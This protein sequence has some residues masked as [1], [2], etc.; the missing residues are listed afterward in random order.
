MKIKLRELGHARAGDKG[1]TSMISFF[2]Y[3]H[4]MYDIVRNLLTPE[5]V[6]NHFQ[7]LVT[8]VKRYEVPSLLALHFVMEGALGGGVTSSLALDPHG[9]CRSFL[10]LDMEI[11]IP[12]SAYHRKE[13]K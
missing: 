12:D 1:N 13:A 5:K 2:V 10:L 3:N 7:S 4:T 6:K 8:S 9:K 11:D